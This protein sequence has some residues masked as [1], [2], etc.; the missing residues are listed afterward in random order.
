TMASGAINVVR[1]S[2]SSVEELLQIYNHSDSVALVVDNPGLLSKLAPMFNSSVTLKFIVIL[3]GEK[4]TVDS[5][6]GN[7]VPLYSY[8]E[9]SRMG[10]DSRKGLLAQTSGQYF[11]YEAIKPDDV[12]TLVYTS[13]TTGNP[14]GVML[15]HENLL[16]QI[17]HLGEIV[18]AI[19]GDRFLSLLP[20]WHMYERSAEYFTFTH[21]IEQVYTN[22]KTLKEDLKRYQPNYLVSVPLVY[23]TLY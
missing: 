21:G 20:P 22:V 4:S 23:D 5:N 10:H 15:T 14:K 13:G 1:G 12:A 8:D 16:H 17:M 9:F 7:K 6:I 3:W 2:Q 11:R 18:P 19:P